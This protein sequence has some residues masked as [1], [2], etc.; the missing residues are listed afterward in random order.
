MPSNARQLFKRK[1]LPD[2]KKLLET[3]DELN[4]VG[5]GRRHLGHITRSGVLSLCSAWELY[6]EEVVLESAQFLMQ[7]VDVPDGL[8]DR[9]KGMLV[10]TA[11]ADKHNFGVLNLCGTGWKAVYQR[12]VVIE[13]AHLNT[14]K[15]GNISSLMHDWL[16]V[17]TDELENAW[18]HTKDDLN[19][20]VTRRGEIAHRGADAEYVRRSALAEYCD[21]IDRFTIDTDNFLRN[22]LCEC[23]DDRRRPWNIIPVH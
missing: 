15:F 3:H 17:D 23:A 11:K 6:V 8:P 20:F 22:H 5:R 1:L 2:V 10:K 7:D 12:A 16:G 13:C 14:P 18:T 4:P 9:I 21:L 19:E